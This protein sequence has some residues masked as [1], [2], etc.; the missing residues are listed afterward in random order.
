MKN[1]DYLKVVAEQQCKRAELVG[2]NKEKKNPSGIPDDYIELEYIESS[3]TQYIDPDIFLDTN[4]YGAETKFSFTEIMAENWA[5][6]V[7]T[8]TSTPLVSWRCGLGPSSTLE[9]I[10]GFTYDNTAAVGNIIVGRS[11]ENTTRSGTIPLLVMAQKDHN[12]N[13]R[14]SKLKMF[15]CKITKDNVLIR[16]FI[17]AQRKNDGVLGMYDLVENI[18]YT[19][20]GTGE[21]IAGKEKEIGI[22]AS[23]PFT[24][25]GENLIDLSNVDIT[26]VIT[27]TSMRINID[28]IK[29]EPNTRYY[30]KSYGKYDP[31][32]NTI[33]LGFR[34]GNNVVYNYYVRNEYFDTPR[35]INPYDNC[36]ISILG[37]T[38]GE[39]YTFNQDT[40]KLML[41]K[42][43]T[44]PT[45]YVPF[46]KPLVFNP[47][48]P[49]DLYSNNGERDFVSML[50]KGY[51]E[52]SGDS[53]LSANTPLKFTG[54][55]LIKIPDQKISANG[56]TTVNENNKIHCYGT[57]TAGWWRIATNVNLYLEA[58]TYSFRRKS[59]GGYRYTFSV[60]NNAGTTRTIYLDA[61]LYVSTFTINE[62]VTLINISTDL[63][64][65]NQEIDYYDEIMLIKGTTPP[66]TFEP[67]HETLYNPTEGFSLNGFNNIYDTFNTI[68]GELTK[69]FGVVDLSSLNWQYT[70]SGANSRFYSTDLL[71]RI[72]NYGSG[73]TQI[74]LL[75]SN[76]GD[77]V[78]WNIFITGDGNVS[79]RDGIIGIRDLNYNNPTTFKQA[80]SGVYLVYELATPQTYQKKAKTLPQWVKHCFD[81]SGRELEATIT[82]ITLAEPVADTYQNANGKITR[83]TNKIE[84]SI[85]NSVAQEYTGYSYLLKFAQPLAK[86]NTPILCDLENTNIVQ[87]NNYLIVEYHNPSFTTQEQYYNY[88]LYEKHELIYEMNNQVSVNSYV[89]LDELEWTVYNSARKIFRAY[90]GNLKT[91]TSSRIAPNI[92]TKKY[93]TVSQDTTWANGMISVDFSTIGNAQYIFICD[94]SKNNATELKNSLTNEI[95]YYDGTKQNI[96]SLLLDHRYTKCI[97]ANGEELEMKKA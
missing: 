68:N 90:V 22:H 94:T 38:R 30:L 61:G 78:N 57:N 41:V 45:K 67:Y 59:I 33:Q 11:T 9:T 24:F 50:I 69:R 15:Y 44:P 25:E 12:G 31:E 18:F 52:K 85:Q 37:L 62:D 17:P 10:R 3:G 93:K 79:S 26:E 74:N 87:D 35:V 8:N 46:I 43:N 48:Q 14:Y 60:R 47:T 1:N 70:E 63:N 7:Y 16:H 97:D 54:E 23:S 82:P 88:F 84:L 40:L 95:A 71:T 86:P 75:C 49:I 4:T 89:R 34:M 72:A 64:D 53:L 80:M 83:K 96:R 32:A 55:N 19:N 51:T 77:I 2:Y 92:Y 81:S 42:S 5:I 21:F 27:G 56:I 65:L 36:R 39:E 28:P 20:R 6:G 91:P 73:A 66:T 76:Y 58:G 29:L 13:I